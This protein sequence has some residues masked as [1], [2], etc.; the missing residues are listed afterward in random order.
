MF[1]FA[2]IE[3]EV[4]IGN[5]GL[6]EFEDFGEVVGGACDVQVVKVCGDIGGGV[7]VWLGVLLGMGRYSYLELFEDGLHG[8][9]EDGG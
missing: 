9:T 5:G 6:G 1:G 7:N 3:L 2:L 4:M 8:D